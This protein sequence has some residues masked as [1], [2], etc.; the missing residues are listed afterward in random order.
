ML[1]PLLCWLSALC[2]SRRCCCCYSPEALPDMSLSPTEPYVAALVAGPAS[3][4]EPSQTHTD[5]DRNFAEFLNGEVSDTICAAAAAAGCA[6]WLCWAAVVVEVHLTTLRLARFSLCRAYERGA[7]K[8]DIRLVTAFGRG[9]AVSHYRYCEAMRRIAEFSAVPVPM[10]VH[11]PVE[12]SHDEPAHESMELSAPVMLGSSLLNH[13]LAATHSLTSHF[14][15][16]E[17]M[18][19]L[20]VPLPL[21][22]SPYVEMLRC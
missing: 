16:V 18:S 2:R 20:S 11:E 12:E 21:F 4:M 6:G 3:S 22:V 8:A 13:V 1:M 9:A 17:M 5:L 10:P 19:G 14:L 7:L 15:Q